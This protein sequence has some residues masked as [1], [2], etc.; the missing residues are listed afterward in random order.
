MQRQRD[1]NDQEEGYTINA[2]LII[3]AWKRFRPVNLDSQE[4]TGKKKRLQPRTK[5]SLIK[6]VFGREFVYRL[7]TAIH[8]KL[9]NFA[10]L[11][12]QVHQRRDYK[13]DFTKY[14]AGKLEKHQNA[15]VKDEADRDSAARADEAPAE[16][17][18]LVEAV[19]KQFVFE[20]D[21]KHPDQVDLNLTL[22]A[23][24]AR[25]DEANCRRVEL[26]DFQAMQ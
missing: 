14:Y 8:L 1:D 15:V 12:H 2:D 9:Y 23:L 21:S 10:E 5:Q 26:F 25:V 22:K 20:S 19:V 13:T 4:L 24:P 17:V 6:E 7:M 3:E 16:E 18:E 11:E